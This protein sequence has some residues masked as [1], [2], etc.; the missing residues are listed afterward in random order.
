MPGMKILLIIAGAAGSIVLLFAFLNWLKARTYKPS[1]E[2]IADVLTKVLSGTMNWYEWDEFTCVPLRH[3]ALLEQIRQAC[4]NME[5]DE[6][7][8]RESEKDEETWIYNEKG[9]HEIQKNVGK[10]TTEHRPLNSTTV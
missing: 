6:Y 4:V 7:V 10:I 5:T 3:D 9:L 8:R 1:R 2:E